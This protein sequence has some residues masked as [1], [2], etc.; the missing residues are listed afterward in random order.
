[1]SIKTLRTRFRAYQLGSEGSSF[2]YYDGSAITLI[3]ARFN[4]TNRLSLSKELKV[5]GKT[6]I[7][8]LHITSWDEDHC[9]LSELDRILTH[10]E[11]DKIEYPGYETESENGKKSL[12]RIVEYLNDCKKN[13]RS[14]TIVK[15]DPAYIRSLE[16]ASRLAYRD[17]FYNPLQIVEGSNDNSTIKLFRRGSFNVASLGDVENVMISARLKRN[18]IFSTEVDV[19]ILAHHGADNGFTTKSFLK[20]TGPTVTICSSNYDNKFEHPKQEIREMLYE[21]G[22]P[23]FTT[24]TGDVIIRSAP[25]HTDK[26]EVLNLVNDNEEL[27]SFKTYVTKKSRF[28]RYNDDSIKNFYKGEKPFYRSIK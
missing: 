18:K 21:L 11:P 17:I 23:V 3:E 4:E 19:M 13:S 7:D 5:C 8:Q 14:V 9:A 15:V 22:I 1:M 6:K 16:E 27:S 28:L 24:K 2:S 12:K 10:L 26:F 25:P 20:S